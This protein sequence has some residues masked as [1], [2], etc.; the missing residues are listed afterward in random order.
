MQLLFR[1]E[2]TGIKLFKVKILCLF[3]TQTHMSSSPFSKVAHNNTQVPGTNCTLERLW[4]T[5]P[6]WKRNRSWDT[7][8]PTPTFLSELSKASEHTY[9]GEQMVPWCYCYLQ[10]EWQMEPS[11]TVYRPVQLNRTLSPKK[12]S[13]HLG[14]IEYGSSSHRKWGQ[15]RWSEAVFIEWPFMGD[16]R[17][18][19]VIELSF[20]EDG[21]CLSGS[22]MSIAYNSQSCCLVLVKVIYIFIWY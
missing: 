18:L 17:A 7:N 12:G 10:S 1:A 8:L 13:H 4:G 16:F 19:Q 3:P 15:L 14:G 11:R 9:L 6:P 20:L 5:F 2:L 22:W 21:C